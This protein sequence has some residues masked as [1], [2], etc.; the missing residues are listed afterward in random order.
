MSITWTLITLKNHPKVRSV[1]EN[2]AQ[3]KTSLL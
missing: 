1:L 2:P 3:R